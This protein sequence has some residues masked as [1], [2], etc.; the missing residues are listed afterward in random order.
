MTTEELFVSGLLTYLIHST[1]L[2]GCASIATR[3]L[4][5]GDL[6]MRRTLWRA[7]LLG[8][9]LS[10][11]LQT[12]LRVEPLSG[13]FT[14]GPKRADV[15]TDLPHAA[16]AADVAA[17]ATA[18]APPVDVRFVLVSSALGLWSVGV[19]FMSLHLGYSYVRFK[20]GLGRRREARDPRLRSGLRTVL[21]AAGVSTRIRLTSSDT[22]SLIHI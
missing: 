12:G 15:G 11:T 10:S 16:V 18:L 20:R 21:A 5:R 22:L 13:A 4:P 17:P 14:L 1:L 2:I 9:L 7:A 8:G 6:Q 3:W 19:L